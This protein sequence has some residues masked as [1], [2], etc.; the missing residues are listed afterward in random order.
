MIATICFGVLTILLV[1]MCAILFSKGGIGQKTGGKFLGAIFVLLVVFSFIFEPKK[2]VGWDL[3]RHFE[4][5]DQM[6]IGGLEFALEDSVYSGMVVYNYFAYFISLLPEKL[7]NLLTTIPLAIDFFIVGY[8]YRKM[9]NKYMPDASE[10]GK[11]LSIIFWLCTFGIEL[12]ISGIRCTLAVSLVVFAIF[13]QMTEKKKIVPIALCVTAVFIHHFALLVIL[14]GLLSKIKKPVILVFI[15]MAFSILAEPISKFILNNVSGEYLTFTF[16][17]VLQTLEGT[18][19][20]SSIRNFSTSVLLIYFSYIAL[21]IYL[22]VISIEAK[23]R[24]TNEYENKI[25]SFAATVGAVAIG[26]AFNYLY[27]QRIMYVVSFA[28]LMVTA[29][30]NKRKSV[31]NWENVFF[32]PISLFMFFFNDIYPFMVNY[33]GTYFLAF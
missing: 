5:L 23:R 1:A 19:F 31:I 8:M 2:F 22:F 11:I 12:A 27:I 7:Q 25:T 24:S 20:I 30:H 14:I 15:S 9:F 17:R 4:I 18:S 10:K 26:L 16:Q 29:L 3:T 21:S 28:F 13:L 33:I 32:V 6:R